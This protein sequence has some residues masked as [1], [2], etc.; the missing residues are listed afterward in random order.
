M[1]A[2]PDL[3]HD[4]M[5]SRMVCLRP[6]SD[7]QA[8]ALSPQRCEVRVFLIRGFVLGRR[9]SDWAIAGENST[10]CVHSGPAVNQHML[11]EVPAVHA[12]FVPPQLGAEVRQLTDEISLCL[13]FRRSV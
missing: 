6:C 13:V 5:E 7:A 12:G 9:R 3:G 11:R 1:L 4:V 2:L 10:F 8:S